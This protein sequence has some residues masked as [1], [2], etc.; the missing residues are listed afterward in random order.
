MARRVFSF[1]APVLAEGR[2]A[3]GESMSITLHLIHL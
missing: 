3:A 2:Q 1:L